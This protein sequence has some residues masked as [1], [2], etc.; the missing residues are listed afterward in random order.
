MLFALRYHVAIV[1]A[2]NALLSF[3]NA[4][5][6]VWTEMVRPAIQGAVLCQEVHAIAHVVSLRPYAIMQYLALS[7]KAT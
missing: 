7:L 6:N 2:S 5:F 4:V 3:V 1:A